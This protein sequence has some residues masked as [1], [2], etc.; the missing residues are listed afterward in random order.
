MGG[1]PDVAKSLVP[2]MLHWPGC[3]GCWELKF[4]NTGRSRSC[5]FFFSGQ[6]SRS[7]TFHFFLNRI[8]T[9]PL[10]QE[11]LGSPLTMLFYFL[12]ILT[13]AY[14]RDD[15]VCFFMS[16]FNLAETQTTM[17]SYPFFA[18]TAFWAN[19]VCFSLCFWKQDCC[20]MLLSKL[21]TTSSDVSHYLSRIFLPDHPLIFPASSHSC[22]WYSC[23]SAFLDIFLFFLLACPTPIFR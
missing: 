7:N 4:S 13:H 21:D 6:S 2:R 23:W 14:L 17:L 18:G 8:H 19:F 3:W 5:S 12:V 15:I 22:H 10:E 16:A 20:K 1:F 9:E 11:L